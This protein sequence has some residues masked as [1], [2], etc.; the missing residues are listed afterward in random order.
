MIARRCVVRPGN[1]HPLVF[2]LGTVCLPKRL[3]GQFLTTLGFEL[4]WTVFH[5]GGCFLFNTAVCMHL[6]SG[7]NHQA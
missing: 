6:G 7:H 3:A 1:P 2:R 4:S 5:P